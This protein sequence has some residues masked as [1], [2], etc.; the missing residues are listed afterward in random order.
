MEK[1]LLLSLACLLP[2]S[3]AAEL[4][5]SGAWIRALPPTQPT[6]AAYLSI[7]NTGPDTVLVTGAGSEIAGRVEIH[8]TREVDGLSRMQQLEALELAPGERLSL[9]PGGTHLMLMELERMPAPGETFELCLELAQSDRICTEAE[10]RK[11][12]G[13]NSGHHHHHHQHQE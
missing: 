5:I 7:A 10:V 12:A 1:R 4:E 8:T 6:T 9:A 2:L 3:A 13:D 11:S